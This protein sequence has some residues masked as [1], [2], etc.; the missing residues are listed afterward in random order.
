MSLV[1]SLLRPLLVEGQHRDH[2]MGIESQTFKAVMACWAGGVTIATTHH[3]AAPV[4]MTVSSFASLTL[5]PPQV[6]I[7]ANQ[8]AHTHAAI[9]AS[10]C[11]AVNM[12]S[13]EQ[14]E[15]G[16]RFAGLQPEITDRFAGIEWFTAQSGAPILPGVGLA[17][18]PITPRLCQR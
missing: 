10:G 2:S 18:L 9:S 16:M 4:G 1:A 11:F 3:E 7:C 8:Q 5:Q 14:Q 6:L 17:G 12:L 13:A 15:W